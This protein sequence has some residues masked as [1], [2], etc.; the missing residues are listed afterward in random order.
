MRH[1]ESAGAAASGAFDL[2]VVLWPDGMWGLFELM[3]L[4]S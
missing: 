1:P 4:L 3:F 2:T